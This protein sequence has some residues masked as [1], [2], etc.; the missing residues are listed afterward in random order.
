M[1][2]R[3]LAVV[4]FITILIGMFWT[5]DFGV[6]PALKPDFVGVVKLAP[7][8]TV[9]L[10][11][12]SVILPADTIYSYQIT[13]EGDT[14]VAQFIPLA[15]DSLQIVARDSGVSQADLLVFS[16]GERLTAELELRVSPQNQS[17]WLNRINL[18]DTL[19]IRLADYGIPGS[20]IIDS[21]SVGFSTD[22]ICTYAGLETGNVRVVGMVPGSTQMS[23]VVW[24]AGIATTLELL[25]QTFIRR[26]T[27]VELFT[28]AGCVPCAPANQLLDEIREN[29]TT[30]AIS[31]IR[32]HVWW[33]IPNDPMYDY[34]RT[35]NVNRVMYYGVT[36]APTLVVDGQMATQT[37]SLWPGQIRQAGSVDSEITVTIESVSQAGSDSVDIA[38][39]LRSYAL[40]DLTDLRIMS[41][42][43]EDS[44]EFAGENGEDIHMQVM[45]DYEVTT[46]IDLAADGEITGVDRLKWHAGRDDIDRYLVTVFVQ[47]DADKKILQA[48]QKSLY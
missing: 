19:S 29:D 11:L 20:E 23:M 37:Q 12:S 27:L 44:V 48:A 28:N 15:G 1:M 46:S 13:S 30:D 8:D 25:L 39:R 3:R 41:V 17:G 16:S 35:E 34:N 36:Q 26:T 10:T 31:M 47:T 5:C 45:R 40:N 18:G 42:V 32:Y 9:L 43:T 6:E 2:R 14:T 38:Y 4:G 33:P 22:S 7:G 24:Q 21:I